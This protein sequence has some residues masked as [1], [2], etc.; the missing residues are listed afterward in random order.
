TNVPGSQSPLYMNGARLTHQFGM[1]PVTHG[2]GLFIAAHSYNGIV[3]FCIT[4]DRQLVP[5]VDVLVRCL[6]ESFSE[7]KKSRRVSA[8]SVNTRTL[9][10]TARTPRK[11]RP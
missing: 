1:G 11:A 2:L 3:S 5:D 4:A 6:E 9:K 10:R 8:N 7:L